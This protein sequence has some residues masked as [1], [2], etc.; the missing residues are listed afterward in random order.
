[1]QALRNLSRSHKLYI[2]LGGVVLFLLSLLLIDW[3]GPFKATDVDSWWI[4]LVLALAAGIYYVSEIAGFDLPLS[5]ISSTTALLA[6]FLVFFWTLTHM[7]DL[8]KLQLGAWL[9]LIGSVAA[10][11]GGL[12]VDQD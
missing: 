12:L 6:T 2:A 5:W 3:F 8:D 7:I 10:V 1:M 11:L 4:A 9:A